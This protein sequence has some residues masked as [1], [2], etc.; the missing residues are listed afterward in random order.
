MLFRGF[1]IIPKPLMERLLG[2]L[3]DMWRGVEY[4]GSA[5][6]I[7]LEEIRMQNYS[8]AGATPEIDREMSVQ[9]GRDGYELYYERSGGRNIDTG[10]PLPSWDGLSERQRE[11]WVA[12]GLAAARAVEALSLPDIGGE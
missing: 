2:L 8:A 9:A 1:Y 5:Y 6:H 4:E 11:A 7:L 12:I 10:G 3:D